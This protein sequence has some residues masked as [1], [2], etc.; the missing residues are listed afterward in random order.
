MRSI[1]AI[2]PFMRFRRQAV[3]WLV[4]GGGLTVLARTKADGNRCKCPK[5][6]EHDHQQQQ[7]QLAESAS[8]AAESS[9]WQIT[10]RLQR[11]AGP[12]APVRSADPTGAAGARSRAMGWCASAGPAWQA[13]NGRS[14]RQRGPTAPASRRW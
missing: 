11:R 9:I 3:Y 8:H 14:R 10:A 7:Q 1:G 12:G 5:R 13:T 6:H 2:S 4:D